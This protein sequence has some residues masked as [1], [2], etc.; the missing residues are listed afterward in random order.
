MKRDLYIGIDPGA[1]GY[2]CQW[3]GSRYTWYPLREDRNS[4]GVNPAVL[5]TLQAASAQNSIVCIEQVHSM[6]LQGVASTFTF[7]FN[8]GYIEGVVAAFKLPI[9]KVTPTKWQR[10]MIEPQDRVT[11]EDGKVQPKPTS[12]NACRRLHPCEDF[13]R[14]KRCRT[15]DDNKC[16]A[17]LICDYA[18]RLNL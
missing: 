4:K 14:N 11:N 8:V 9:C 15:Y 13:R 10:V 1:N 6:P 16:D 2:L 17:T 12:Y 18:Q 3:D 7:G 5:D